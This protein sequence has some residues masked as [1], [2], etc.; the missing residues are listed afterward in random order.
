[1]P[2]QQL[3]VLTQPHIG[4][5]IRELRIVTGLTQEQFAA[6]LGVTYGTV[7][8]WE[9]G[10]MQPSPLALKQVDKVLRRIGSDGQK[11]LEL[12]VPSKSDQQ[13]ASTKLC[14]E[15]PLENE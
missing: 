8:R 12:H 3:L 4:N 15:K 7:N 2:H 10:K 1:M 6:K 11:L 5:L 13:P 14:E 9:R